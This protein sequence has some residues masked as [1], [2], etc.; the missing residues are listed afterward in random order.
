LTKPL[1]TSLSA[2]T[3]VVDVNAGPS[4]RAMSPLAA[5]VMAAAGEYC[6]GNGADVSHGGSLRGHLLEMQAIYCRGRALSGLL[7]PS[8]LPSRT[9]FAN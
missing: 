4:S 6:K 3:M 7:P 9:I 2:A 8:P 5:S 1:L